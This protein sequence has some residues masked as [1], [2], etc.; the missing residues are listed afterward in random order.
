MLGNTINRTNTIFYCRHWQPTVAFY[1]D[2]LKL[3]VSHETDW[4]VE[5][6]LTGDS[7]LSVA[8]A[9]H[10]SI[11]PVNGQGST[12]SLKVVGLDSLHRR[13]QSAGI[14]ASAIRRIWGARA[15]YIRDPEGHRLE[16]WA[17]KD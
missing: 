1:R 3:S 2:L 15:F 17:E 16:F 9:R 11:E 13:L 5:F 4:F 8:D 7:C 12:L 14:E 6:R 10:A